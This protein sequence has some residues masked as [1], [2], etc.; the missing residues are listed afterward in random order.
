MPKPNSPPREIMC[1]T[2]GEPLT[3]EHAKR[4]RAAVAVISV[5]YPHVRGFQ[6]SDFLCQPC[7]FARRKMKGKHETS[8]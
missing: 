3:L 2:C 7:F 1:S 8:A 6:E 4:L 5:L